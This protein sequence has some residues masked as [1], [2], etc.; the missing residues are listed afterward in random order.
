M[1]AR[2]HQLVWVER[3][4]G[5]CCLSGPR[6]GAHFGLRGGGSP[7]AFRKNRRSTNAALTL[8][9]QCVAEGASACVGILRLAAPAGTCTQE[10]PVNKAWKKKPLK[11]NG[12]PSACIATMDLLK[13]RRSCI[14]LSP[15]ASPTVSSILLDC[16]AAL[17]CLLK[18]RNTRGFFVHACLALKIYYVK[19]SY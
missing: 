9:H 6:G 1:L 19:N 4:T 3:T 13:K 11:Q 18:K 2:C 16:L 7:T 14:M 5:T 10:N 12:T 17:S 15:I 8:L